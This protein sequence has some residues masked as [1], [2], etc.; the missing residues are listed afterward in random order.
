[1]HHNDPFP[2]LCKEKLRGK[3]INTVQSILQW[4][5]IWLYR[6]VSQTFPVH[7]LVISQ[8]E[9]LSSG[10]RTPL[11]ACYSSLP[12]VG[13]VR[14]QA[15]T[16]LHWCSNM[17]FISE[18]PQKQNPLFFSMNLEEYSVSSKKSLTWLTFMSAEATSKLYLYSKHPSC[19]KPRY[20]G[21]ILQKWQCNPLIVFSAP[22]W[23]LLTKEH[24]CLEWNS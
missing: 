14:Q 9:M 3:R 1:M 6:S 17:I 20:P 4:A 22:V 19:F 13:Q 10:H 15:V 18:P 12:W 23:N 8:T 16:R 2:I 24:L 11:N 7:L 21:T 5:N